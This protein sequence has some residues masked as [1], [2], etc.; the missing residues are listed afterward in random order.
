MQFIFKAH[1]T[2]RQISITLAILRGF[3]IVKRVIYYYF[4]PP[5]YFQDKKNN[6]ST[7]KNRSPMYRSVQ[8]KQSCRNVSVKGF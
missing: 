6:S 8:S 4:M 1:F 3:H 2:L 7:T 5:L